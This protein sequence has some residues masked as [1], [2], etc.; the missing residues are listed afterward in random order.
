MVVEAGFRRL[1]P[2]LLLAPA[3]EGRQHDILQ[4]WLLSHPAC[5]LTAVHAGH[6]DVQEHSVWRIAS[7]HL[8]RGRAVVRDPYFM[9]LQPEPGSIQA[10]RA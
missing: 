5:D 1:P 9:A 10:L 3:R 8:Q 2:I 4:A 7:R 6:S